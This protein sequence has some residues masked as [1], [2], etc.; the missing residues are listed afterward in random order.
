[1]YS[2]GFGQLEVVQLPA[3]EDNYLYLLSTDERATW[4]AIDPGDAAVID[5][6]LEV[7]GGRLESILLTHHH[8]DHVG[9]A[10]GL[11]EKHGALIYGPQNCL[12][13]CEV[14]ISSV[15]HDA[16]EFEGPVIEVLDVPGHTA[17]HVAYYLPQSSCVFVGDTLFAMG[18]GRLFTGTMEDLH[19]SVQT[20]FSLPDE[21]QVFCAHEYTLR[22]FAFAESLGRLSD[23]QIMRKQEVEA[24]R[25]Q[26]LPSVPFA[27]ADEKAT[28]PFYTGSLERFNKYRNLRDRF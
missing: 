21:T 11:K 19:A 28:S 17:C 18:C 9:G 6:G 5:A 22:N 10:A 14:G 8:M 12:K 4:I 1:L 3:F 26:G 23:E 25:Q 15:D 27:V 2:Y 20:L 7:L 24:K 13:D 16:R